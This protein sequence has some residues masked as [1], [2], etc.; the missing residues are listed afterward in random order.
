MCDSFYLYL[1]SELIILQL[2]MVVFSFLIYYLHSSIYIYLVQILILGHNPGN[3]R[4][5]SLGPSILL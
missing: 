4:V 2:Y 5:H 3:A 1:L